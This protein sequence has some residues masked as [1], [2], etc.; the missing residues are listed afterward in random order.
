MHGVWGT[1]KTSRSNSTVPHSTH[2][3]PPMPSQLVWVITGT[4]YVGI[5]R[6]LTFAALNRGDK[7]IATA[8]ARSISALG[9]LKDKGADIL[10]LDVTS[11]LENLKEIAAAAVKIHGRVDVLVNNAGA[12]TTA[13]ILEDQSP[14]ETLQQMNTNILGPLNVTR[15]FLPYMRERRVG[16][17][18]WI[19]SLGG[20]MSFP[21]CG[22]Y[23]ASKY[24]M[25]GVS[26]ALHTEIAPLGLRS[27]CIE[28]GNYRT[29]FLSPSHRAPLRQKIE[30]YKEMAEAGDAFVSGF[31]G[32]E[33]GSP[34]KAT[35]IIVDIVR[36]EGMAEGKDVPLV[37][38]LG[39][40]CYGGV[41]KVCEDTLRRLEEWKEVSI[42]TDLDDTD[43]IR[44]AI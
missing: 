21:L 22:A 31:H 14:E 2:S 16:T 4:S 30:D 34:A 10:E 13:A 32:K 27:I 26:Q 33:P 7:V 19:G 43:C 38:S 29:E 41:K 44:L 42:S 36:G 17:I 37:L 1:Y 25:R 39:R 28:L 24:A 12:L 15:A 18:I 5:G 11:P 6:E 3:L 9:D 8:R 35:S 40:D 23:C 20:W